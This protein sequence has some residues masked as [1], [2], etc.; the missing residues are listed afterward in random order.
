[1]IQNIIVGYTFALVGLVPTVYI[2][3]VMIADLMKENTQ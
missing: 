1:M 2:I 3:L